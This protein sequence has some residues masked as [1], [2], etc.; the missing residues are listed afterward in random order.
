MPAQAAGEV[1]VNDAYSALKNTVLNSPT[2]VLA[3]DTNPGS[4]EV[5][6]QAAP[7][8]GSALLDAS[9]GNFSYTPTTDFV[10]VDTFTYCFTAGIGC[11]A[12]PAATVTITVKQLV[13]NDDFLTVTGAKLIITQDALLTNDKGVTS[14]VAWVPL[15]PTTY[16]TFDADPVTGD[17]V[18]IPGPG[19]V[20]HDSFPYCLVSFTGP[21]NAAQ[22]AHRLVAP[23]AAAAPPIC[24]SNVAIVNITAPFSRLAKAV[25]DN[26][27]G[28]LGTL[29]N[30][31]TAHGLLANDSHPKDLG[32]VLLE[33]STK[34][35]TLALGADGHFSYTPNSGFVGTDTFTYAL[36]YNGTPVPTDPGVNAANGKAA[37][38]AGAA[39]TVDPALLSNVATVRIVVQAPPVP[40]AS[41][42]AA[43]ELPA[44]GAEAG[45][46]GWAAMLVLIGVVLLVAASR[47]GRTAQ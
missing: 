25:N 39:A 36:K 10:G 45:Q 9:S 2:S 30:V 19:F 4:L 31:S 11:T 27:T 26:Y 21:V 15:E 37:V 47:R 7:T 32:T 35:G 33:T 1:A 41:A 16:G 24:A 46:L 8:H 42:T 22:R 13:A 6:I 23:N 40:A 38:V 29:L 14:D 5:I 34:H 12:A 43:P 17:L 3:N 28:T 20:G 18:Y 44:T